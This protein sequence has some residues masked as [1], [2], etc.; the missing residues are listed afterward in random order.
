MS[1]CL[2]C[3][4]ADV[5][6]PDWTVVPRRLF[7]VVALPSYAVVA[8]VALSS[9]AVVALVALPNAM[10]LFRVAYGRLH[11]CRAYFRFWLVHCRA[12][13]PFLL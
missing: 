8:P 1:W 6:L 12:R 7:T 2:L 5:L 4:A 10:L 9:F 11:F 13:L 3:F